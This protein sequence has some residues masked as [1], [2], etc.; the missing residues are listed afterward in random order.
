VV[1]EQAERRRVKS[2]FSRIV[3]PKIVNELLAA[4]TL[5]LGGARREIT[6]FFADVRGFTEFTDTSQER[7]A[8]F[9]RSRNLT[10]EAAEACFDEQAKETLNTV[11][12]YL[13]LVADTVIQADGT[14]DKFIGDCVMAFWRVSF[15]QKHHSDNVVSDFELGLGFWYAVAPIIGSCYHSVTPRVEGLTNSACSKQRL[16]YACGTIARRSQLRLGEA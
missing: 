7:V 1:F 13:G 12:L 8:E 2:I 14:L 4:E 11:N 5:S 16:L 6:V 10:G 15:Y 9:V 3:S